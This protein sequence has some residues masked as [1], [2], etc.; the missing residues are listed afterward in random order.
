[1]QSSLNWVDAI[2]TFVPEDQKLYTWWSYR[3]KDWK[4]SNRGRRLDH[5][6][7]TPAL[8]KAIKKHD[9]LKDARDWTQTSDHVPVMLE[10][11]L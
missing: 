9:I 6:W 1:M 2:R 3:N 4:A 11:D 7:V 8:Q 5:I 10:L